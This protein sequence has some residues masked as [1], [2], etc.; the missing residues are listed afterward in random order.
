MAVYVDKPFAQYRG[1]HM[2]HMMADTLDE[3]HEMADKIGV[4]RKWFQPLSSPHYDIAKSKR[5]L[6]IRYGAIEADRN[7]IVELIRKW[8]D[9]ENT[10]PT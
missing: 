10:S 2:C 9:N 5:A 8:R 3:L 4:K 7:K 1:M 6:A